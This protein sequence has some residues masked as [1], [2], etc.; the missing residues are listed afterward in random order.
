MNNCVGR[1]GDRVPS[2]ESPVR[3]A[4]R[5][6][7]ENLPQQSRN[8]LGWLHLGLVRATKIGRENGSCRFAIISCWVGADR[9]GR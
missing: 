9:I 2:R 3:T 4:D 8:R 7:A 1:R 6:G 5:G